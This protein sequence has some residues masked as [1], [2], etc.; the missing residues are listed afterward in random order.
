MI[1]NPGLILSVRSMLQMFVYGFEI[2]NILEKVTQDGRL[3]VSTVLFYEKESGNT[4]VTTMRRERGEEH[5][6]S[7]KR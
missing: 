6:E 4:G 1:N 7:E 3:E 2:T 5:W